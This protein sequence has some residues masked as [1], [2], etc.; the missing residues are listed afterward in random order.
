MDLIKDLQRASHKLKCQLTDNL[1]DDNVS[2]SA[3]AFETHGSR[4]A[5]EGSLVQGTDEE[6]LPKLVPDDKRNL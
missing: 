4:H 5:L 6:A 1:L 2:S 3:V